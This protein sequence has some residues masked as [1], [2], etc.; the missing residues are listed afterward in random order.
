[1]AHLS[2]FVLPIVLP[3]IMW[4][5]QKDKPGTKW[6]AGQSKQAMIFQILLTVGGVIVGLVRGVLTLLTFGIGAILFIP[7][8]GLYGLAGVIV[9]FYATWQAYNG[10]DYKYPFL[11][12]F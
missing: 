12:K 7:L 8:M 6:V 9:C 11:G 1:M 10:K 4:M 5:I 2:L 3:L